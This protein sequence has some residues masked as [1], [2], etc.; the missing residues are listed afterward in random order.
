MNIV[1]AAD[2]QDDRTGK[3][4]ERSQKELRPDTRVLKKIEDPLVQRRMVAFQSGSI[5]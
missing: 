4:H 5:L 2:Q 1:E 3:P